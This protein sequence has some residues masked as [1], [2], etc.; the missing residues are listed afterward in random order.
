MA[1]K[2]RRGVPSGSRGNGLV[3]VTRTLRV[4]D[5]EIGPV[6]SWWDAP[7]VAGATYPCTGGPLR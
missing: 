5:A 1:A 2:S 7:N 6:S 3:K 4:T